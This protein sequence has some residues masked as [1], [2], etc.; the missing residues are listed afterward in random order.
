MS[1]QS[2]FALSLSLCGETNALFR[3]LFNIENI[4]SALETGKLKSP[5]SEQ[6]DMKD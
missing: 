4:R 2:T 6:K 5:V 3:E 1:V